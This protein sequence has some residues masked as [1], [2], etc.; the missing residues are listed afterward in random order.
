M[1]ILNL[2]FLSLCSLFMIACLDPID[3]E[4][5]IPE[6]VVTPEVTWIRGNLPILSSNFHHYLPLLYKPTI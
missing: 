6:E 3:I 1:K 4:S 2:F 5:N